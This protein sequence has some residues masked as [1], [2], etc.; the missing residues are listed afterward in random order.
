MNFQYI[1]HITL[2]SQLTSSVVFLAENK[3]KRE[4]RESFFKKTDARID[5]HACAFV[6]R[7]LVSKKTMMKLYNTNYLFL[8]EK[9]IK[10]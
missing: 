8:Q 2:L 10:K 6:G 4:R 3:K 7:I 5:A 1:A 9:K